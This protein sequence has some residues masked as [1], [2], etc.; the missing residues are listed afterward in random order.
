MSDYSLPF[1]T[2]SCSQSLLLLFPI[3]IRITNSSPAFLAELYSASQYEQILQAIFQAL[4]FP[5]SYSSLSHLSCPSLPVR[6]VYALGLMH[7]WYS[8]IYLNHHPGNFLHLPPKLDL[9][10]PAPPV[11]LS[12]SLDPYFGWVIGIIS[13]SSF[14]RKNTGRKKFIT[15]SVSEN[16][17]ILLSYLIVVWA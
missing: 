5:K 17:F 4:F 13:S 14:F 1:L 3:V 7:C 12:L 2:I 9:W 16:I 6:I 11:F 15:P 8:R 10:F